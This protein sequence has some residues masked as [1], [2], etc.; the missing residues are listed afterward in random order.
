MELR[1]KNNRLATIAAR[2]VY[3]DRWGGQTS[4]EQKWRGSDSVYGESIFT[5]RCELIGV[6][7]LPLCEK[8][9]FQYSFN[10][11]NQNSWYGKVPYKAAQNIAFAQLYWTKQIIPSTGILVGL[12]FRYT[13][14]DDNTIGTQSGY[15]LT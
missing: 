12:P 5:S 10:N 8:I 9:F 15:S 13:Y 6:Y 11:H 7:Q 2:F 14:Y 4:W 1:K 3:E